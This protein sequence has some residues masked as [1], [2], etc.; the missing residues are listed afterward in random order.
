M[1]VGTN[2]ENVWK[3]IEMEGKFTK[4]S[5]CTHH[6]NIFNNSLGG[7]HTHT[8]ITDKSNFKKLDIR[9][10]LAGTHLV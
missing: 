9:W 5:H 7:E 3:K 6:Y 4:T 8:D 1:E 2:M 10:P